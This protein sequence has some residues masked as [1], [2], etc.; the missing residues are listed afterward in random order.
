MHFGIQG[1][2]GLKYGEVADFVDGAQKCNR[3]LCRR[4]I[5]CGNNVRFYRSV[6]TELAKIVLNVIEGGL[7]KNKGM[8][9][10]VSLIGKGYPQ[11]S[12]FHSFY[13]MY[14]AP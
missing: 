2:A 10:I 4:E 5:I 11:F 7:E 13:Q 6:R 9:K 1:I 12:N 14:G 8:E 3:R